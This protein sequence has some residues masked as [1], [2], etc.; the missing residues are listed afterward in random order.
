MLDVYVIGMA[1]FAVWWLLYTVVTR[2]EGQVAKKLLLLP[3]LALIW[4]IGVLMLLYVILLLVFESRAL[5]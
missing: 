3:A 2:K 1:V 4:P 5:R